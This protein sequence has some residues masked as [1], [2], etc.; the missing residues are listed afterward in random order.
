MLAE[1]ATVQSVVGASEMLGCERRCA[2]WLSHPLLLSSAKPSASSSLINMSSVWQSPPNSPV[3]S[4]HLGLKHAFPCQASAGVSNLPHCRETW[5]GAVSLHFWV[6]LT[7]H[8]TDSKDIIRMLKL[9]GVQMGPQRCAPSNAETWGLMWKNKQKE[10]ICITGEF[11]P[12]SDKCTILKA[13]RMES[14]ASY[15][16]SLRWVGN[17]KHGCDEMVSYSFQFTF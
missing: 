13:S 8:S 4:Q 9:Q 6:W 11:I 16:I 12:P 14:V 7:D 5:L 10:Q 1:T 17:E 2:S 3:A 15:K